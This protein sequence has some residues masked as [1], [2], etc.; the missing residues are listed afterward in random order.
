MRRA[1][2]R[3]IMLWAKARGYAWYDLYGIAPPGQPEHQWAGFSSFKRKLG[4]QDFNFIP[5]LDY[6]Y[7]AEAYKDFENSR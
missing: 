4:G 2:A 7:D 1:V 3:L 5:A 6:I